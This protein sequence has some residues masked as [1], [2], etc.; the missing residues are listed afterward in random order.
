MPIELYPSI[1]WTRDEYAALR[2]ARWYRCLDNRAQEF[3]KVAAT[4]EDAR[5]ILREYVREPFRDKLTEFGIC[6]S[7]AGV[8]VN[9]VIVAQSMGSEAY[10]QADEDA[11]KLQHLEHEVIG[12][13]RHLILLAQHEG[14]R[15]EERHV[16]PPTPFAI[17]WLVSSKGS[18]GRTRDND[19]L[20]DRL[21]RLLDVLLL[22]SPAVAVGD[23]GAL[24]Q[25]TTPEHARE[26]LRLAGYSRV[27]FAEVV[28]QIAKGCCG[29]MMAG[30]RSDTHMSPEAARE[31]L[32]NAEADVGALARGNIGVQTLL[33]RVVGEQGLCRWEAQTILV[34]SRRILAVLTAEHGLLAKASRGE[35]LMAEPV[36]PRARRPWWRRLLEALALLRRPPEPVAQ[37]M[38]GHTAECATALASLKETQSFLEQVEKAGALWTNSEY[39]PPQIFLERWVRTLERALHAD[40]REL[41]DLRAAVSSDADRIFRDV[42]SRVELDVSENLSAAISEW[43]RAVTSLNDVRQALASD[44][45]VI[46]DGYVVGGKSITAAAAVG[47]FNF[48]NKISIH[49]R[50]VPYAKLGIWPGVRPFFLVVSEAFDK[51]SLAW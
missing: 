18:D 39:A 38:T 51:N 40:L 1:V 31:F 21:A 25:I 46:F 17:P 15:N 24:Q 29:H 47:A 19:A 34:E 11:R 45:L 42:A 5:N 50:D 10:G 44:R 49:G 37:R 33:S 8:V 16:N 28:K 22:T 27:D 13:R 20:A 6:P 7:L 3:V 23:P 43:S 2:V 4:W 30:C 26:N 41:A 35:L 9:V 14:L 12:F 32:R 36:A 48:G